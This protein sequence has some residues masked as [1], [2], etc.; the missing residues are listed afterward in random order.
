[1]STQQDCRNQ[2]SARKGEAGAAFRT[3]TTFRCGRTLASKL[4][5]PAELA[6]HAYSSG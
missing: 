1:M 3:S 2:V 5:E 6:I 4:K